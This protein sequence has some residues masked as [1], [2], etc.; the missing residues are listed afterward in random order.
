MVFELQFLQL[1]QSKSFIDVFNPYAD[2]CNTFDLPKAAE[3]RSTN[4]LLYLRKMVQNKPTTIWVAEAL[5]HRGGRRTGIAMTDDRSIVKLSNLLD[6]QGIRPAC[7]NNVKEMTAN[8]IWSQL[9]QLSTLEYP[10]LWNI[11]PYHP[12]QKDNP[13][14]NRALNSYEI[15][16]TEDITRQLFDFFAFEKIVSIGKKSYQRLLHL[17]Y[18]P[19]YVRHPSHGGSKLFKEQLKKIYYPN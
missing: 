14:S 10:F 7:Q 12:H 1:L 3:I 15:A 6:I 4:L 5:G 17:G 8:Q 11:F 2:H 13:I 16:E 18:E 9:E 19:T